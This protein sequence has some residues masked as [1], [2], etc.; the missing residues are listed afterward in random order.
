MNK[1][2]FLANTSTAK[3]PFT[4][5]AVVK[6]GVARSFAASS[7]AKALAPP[8]WPL[9]RGMT[10][11]PP[12]SST[13]TAGSRR[14]S[15]TWG[16][17][18]RTAM[19]EAQQKIRASASA[20]PAP[21]QSEAEAVKASSSPSQNLGRAKVRQSWPESFNMSATRAARARPRAV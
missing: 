2:L 21:A 17:M 9:K 20:K 12:S 1:S 15:R 14:L 18:A 8:R 10:K 4:S 16:A 3:S 11:V 7:S 5:V 6:T 13:S 19:P